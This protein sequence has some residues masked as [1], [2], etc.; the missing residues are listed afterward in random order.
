MKSAFD[1]IV[2]RLID[3]KEYSKGLIVKIVDSKLLSKNNIRY[4][5]DIENVGNVPYNLL[6]VGVNI[7]YRIE[8]LSKYITHEEDYDFSVRY[9]KQ[10]EKNDIE[11]IFFSEIPFKD[12]YHI[13]PEFLSKMVPTLKTMTKLFYYPYDIYFIGKFLPKIN[14]DGKFHLYFK[15]EEI[16]KS[17]NPDFIFQEDSTEEHFN[18]IFKDED[19]FGALDELVSSIQHLWPENFIVEDKHWSPSWYIEDIQFNE[20]YIHFV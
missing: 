13:T 12:I 11:D 7:K 4:V 18:E 2:N 9:I 16:D 15:I 10:E 1:K 5:F 3:N 20:F 17:K 19:E 14:Y 6:V 8:Q